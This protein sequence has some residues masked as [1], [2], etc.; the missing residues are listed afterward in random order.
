[1]ILGKAVKL[2]LR[3]P[4]DNQPPPNVLP[5][6]GTE[7]NAHHDCSFHQTFFKRSLRSLVHKAQVEEKSLIGTS[8]CCQ[9]SSVACS[10]Y[11]RVR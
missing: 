3:K 1:M 5:E 10:N 7:S 2:T 4:G 8:L 11:W 6:I 9:G